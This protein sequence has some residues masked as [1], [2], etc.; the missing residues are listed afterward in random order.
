MLDDGTS[1]GRV[2]FATG[3]T[4]SGGRGQVVQGLSCVK[5]TKPSAAYDYAHLNLLVDGQLIAVPDN[6]G[7]AS[8]GNSEI[9]DPALR[10]IGCYY[11]MAT[12][13]TSG[14]IRTQ[15][16]SVYTLGQFFALWGQPLSY[17][18]VAG[19]AGKPVK[20]FIR[21]GATLTEYTGDLNTLPLNPN[22]EITIEIGTEVSEIPRFE[23]TNPPPPAATPEVIDYDSPNLASNGQKGV[24]EGNTTNGKGGQGDPVDG[25]ACYGPKNGNIFGYNFHIHSHLSIFR[26]GVR[27]AIPADIGIVGS[28]SVPATSCHYPLHTHDETGV[29]HVEALD[30]IKTTLGQVF[31][32]WGQP[33]S[34]TNIAGQTNMPVVVYIQDGGNLRKYQGDLADIELKSYRS[35]VIQLGTPLNAIPTYD[36]ATESQ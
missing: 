22:R 19:Y 11:P 34:R 1:V 30:P 7:L 9:A 23:W 5:P 35:I 28:E 2:T 17:G 24:L 33:L 32:I 4:A 21:D 13:D 14:K 31:N 15:P 18:N 25:I 16:G 27:L 3:A 12:N 36:L 26:D 6:I 20:V 29:I 10:E 8:P